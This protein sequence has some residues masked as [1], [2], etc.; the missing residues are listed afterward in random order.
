MWFGLK[1]SIDYLREGSGEK[2]ET[3]FII[4]AESM[5]KIASEWIAARKANK[6]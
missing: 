6:K 3:G 4:P 5:D 1:A 2:L